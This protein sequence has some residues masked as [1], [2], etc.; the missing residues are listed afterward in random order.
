MLTSSELAKNAI[1][2]NELI[3]SLAGQG[4]LDTAAIT[5]GYHTFNDLYKQRLYLTAALFNDHPALA[6]KTRRH[7][8]GSK[9]FG[10]GWFYVEI[11]T[12]EGPYGYH[13]ENQFW[14]LFDIPERD[15]ARPWDGYKPKD[16]TRLLSLI[17]YKYDS[18]YKKDIEYDA[19]LCCC[20]LQTR[21]TKGVN[22]A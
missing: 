14:D 3:T 2:L 10:G 21:I 16:A 11:K 20:D 13:Y 22:D 15:K 1:I 7:A 9:P 5:D 17:K 18:F 12:P 19:N 6:Y 8:D 4:N